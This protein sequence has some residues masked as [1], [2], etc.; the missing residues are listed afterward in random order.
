MSKK[1]F[2]IILLILA[3]V[4]LGVFL[5]TKDFSTAEPTKYGVTFSKKYAIELELDWH[6]SYL[7]ILDQLQVTNLRLVAYWDD[8]EPVQ[9]SFDFSDLDWQ[10]TE[11]QNRGIDIGLVVGRRAPRWPECHDPDWL[12]NLAPLA[13]QQQQLEYIRAVIERYQSND[14]I[15]SWQVENEPLFALFGECPLPDKKFLAQEIELVRS[16]DNTRPIVVTD[17]G[18]L[19]HWQGAAS[20]ADNLGITLY[21]VVWNKYLGFWDYFFLPPAAYRYKADLTKFFHKNLDKVIVIE[22]QM[23]PWTLDKPMIELTLEEQERSF[24]LQRFKDNINYVEQAGFAE[25]Y[26][27]GVEYW[28]WLDQQGYPNIWQEAKELW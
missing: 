24:T 11:A 10:I 3:I 20:L 7:A 25:V 18:E 5:F 15:K 28:Y 21:R 12:I 9:D 4:W 19:N 13:I 2:I 6:Q 14:V 16:L 22:L 27:W 17:S 23:E 26:L 1:L 8:I